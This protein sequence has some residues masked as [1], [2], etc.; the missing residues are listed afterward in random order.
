MSG[1]GVEFGEDL[2]DISEFFNDSS[3]VSISEKVRVA[4]VMCK[5]DKVRCDVQRPCVR[6]VSKNRQQL[7]IDR[8]QSRSE[9]I[10][11]STE[12]KA[13]KRKYS[14]RKQQRE[15]QRE[16]VERFVVPRTIDSNTDQLVRMKRRFS[17]NLYEASRD[18]LFNESPMFLHDLLMNCRFRWGMF[19]RFSKFYVGNEAAEYL[20]NEV[21][22]IAMQVCLGNEIAENA[23]VES[24]HIEQL[25]QVG[26][27]PPLVVEDFNFSES[28][29]TQIEQCFGVTDLSGLGIHSL[30]YFYSEDGRNA[31]F[32]MKVNKSL[33][34]LMG[35]SLPSLFESLRCFQDRPDLCPL[36]TCMMFA[37]SSWQDISRITIHSDLTHS[38]SLVTRISLQSS[39]QDE[40]IECDA[41]FVAEY[42]PIL[43]VRSFSVMIVKPIDSDGS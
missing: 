32:V 29:Q 10:Q 16:P 38:K 14:K 9:F 15:E 19:Q 24:S 25:P 20:M 17:V 30:D 2:L 43:N 36:V 8:P 39:V 23:L 33:E 26:F 5:I 37:E 34:K 4:C 31:S 42:H 6:C 40:D 22:K 13:V 27:F 21:V 1:K 7:C 35:R 18:V 3:A 28:I 41:L 12:M 11:L